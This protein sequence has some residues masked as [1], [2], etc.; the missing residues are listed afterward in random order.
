MGLT[1]KL[2]VQL[3]DTND[4]WNVTVRLVVGKKKGG[5][6]IA[7]ATGLFNLKSKG[8]LNLEVNVIHSFLI[9]RSSFLADDECS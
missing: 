8:L 9:R 1:E 4:K 2:R 7:R 3:F 6:E 5:K